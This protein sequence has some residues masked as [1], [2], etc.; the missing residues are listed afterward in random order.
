MY[1]GSI[2]HGKIIE[3][4]LRAVPGSYVRDY[5]HKGGFITV[6][7]NYRTLLWKDQTTT[8]KAY[9]DVPD[10]TLLN[11]PRGPVYPRTQYAGVRLVR[12]GWREQFRKSMRHISP[13][14]MKRI[15]R[16]MGYGQIFPEG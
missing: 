4:Y 9:R 1:D 14:Q 3:T 7:R 6:C 13:D 16:K 10:V 12:P 5:R 11:L 8:R 2:D 15:T